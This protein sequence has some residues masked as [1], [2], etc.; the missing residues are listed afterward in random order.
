MQTLRPIFE[1]YAYGM[2]R[3]EKEE[4]D[5]EKKAKEAENSQERDASTGASDE[6]RGVSSGD[7]PA[8]PVTRR[9]LCNENSSRKRPRE[10]SDVAKT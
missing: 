6:S 7:A 8:T 5:A 1:Q 10:G 4:E 9:G 3:L 2:R